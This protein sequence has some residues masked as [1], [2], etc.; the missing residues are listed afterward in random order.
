[1]LDALRSLEQKRTLV[2]GDEEGWGWNG[3]EGD[4]WGDVV[5]FHMLI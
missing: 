3:T 4:F 5:R 1:M 2:G